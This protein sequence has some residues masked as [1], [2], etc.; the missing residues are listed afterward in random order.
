MRAN[1]FLIV[2]A[3]FEGA[4][5]VL[6]LLAPAL[7]FGFLFGWRE[8][9]PETALMGRV[10]GAAVLGLSAASWLARGD[11]DSRALRGLLTGLLIYNVVAT[12][13]LAFA[14]A[15]LKMAGLLLW[16]AV[17]F[18]VALTAWSVPCLRRRRERERR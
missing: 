7:V 17:V 8:V 5:G 15:I 4:T 9:G 2:T 11:D 13:L 18:H 10:A 14:G 1:V 6:L 12:V 16:P 3:M